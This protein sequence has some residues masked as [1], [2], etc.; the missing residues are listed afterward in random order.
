[1]A[2]HTGGW[3]WTI[4]VYLYIYIYI[5][6]KYFVTS[7]KIPP[8]CCRVLQYCLN[9][10]LWKFVIY[11]IISINSH[12]ASSER[13]FTLVYKKPWNDVKIN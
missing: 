6:Y 5:L 11:R 9:Y 10:K 8:A 3:K 1:M 13:L 4:E 12:E 7:H 2:E